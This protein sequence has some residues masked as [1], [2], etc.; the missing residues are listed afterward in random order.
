MR[1]NE[2]PHYDASINT[3]GCCP[4]FNPGGW[5]DQQ[6]HFADKPFLRAT[7]HSVLH[8]PVNMGNVFARVS[9]H[10]DN[11]GASADGQHIV[12]S[13]D[14]SP[15]TSEH[16]FSVAKSV[17]D[18]EMTTLRGEFV[19]KVFE[20]AFEQT[21]EWHDEMLDLARQRNTKASDVYFFYTTCPKC[22][23]AYGKNYV[24]GVAKTS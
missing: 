18:E 6:L 8:V 10:I 2:T 22:A 21:R 5:D 11:A 23:A 20:G 13:R 16:L 19:T 4:K 12:L 7:T 1:T 3:T 9:E 17:P 14:L 24:V 15:W